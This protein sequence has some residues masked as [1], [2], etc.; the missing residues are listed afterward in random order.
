MNPLSASRTSVFFLAAFLFYF[1]ASLVWGQ[2][3]SSS[4]LLVG[5][6]A[7]L[8]EI[9]VKLTADEELREIWGARKRVEEIL[10]EVSREFEQLIQVRFIWEGWS[11]WDSDDRITRLED[12][13]EQLDLRAEKQGADLLIAVTA[14]QNLELDYTGFSL[15]R[16]G[17]VVV[18][19]TPDRFKLKRLIVHELGHVFGAV[20]VPVANSIM[21]CLGE[22]TRFDPDNL[23]II[24]LGRTRS[25]KPFGFPFPEEV[26]EELEKIYLRIRAKILEQKE[27]QK[28]FKEREAAVTRP[29]DS[30]LKRKAICLSDCFLM[31][32]QLQLEKAE[33]EKAISYSEE[34]LVLNPED[35]EALNL[36]AIALRRSGQVE[37]AAEIYQTIL[38][39][40]PEQPRILFNLGIA[41]GRMNR[42]EEAKRI[43]QRVLELKPDFFEAHNNLGEIFL[44]ENRLDE[45]ERHFFKTIE[46]YEG[47]GLAYSN[48]AEVYSRRNELDKAR[49]YVE[50]ALAIDPGMISALNIKGNLLRREGRL[51]E[52]L[53]QYEKALKR[54]PRYEKALYNMGIISTDL[55]RWPEARAYFLKALEV[56]P[57]FGEAQAGLGLCYLH[58]K[59][60]DEAIYHLNKARELG[61]Q[62]PVI[63]VN[64]SYA[65]LAKGDWSRAE[66]EALKATQEQP[67]LAL[68]YNNLGIALAQQ[69]KMEQARQALNRA[70]ELNPVDRDSVVNLATVEFSLGNDDRA[71]QLFLKAV[72]L[73]PGHPGNGLIYNNLAVIY[74]RKAQYQQSW[75]FCLRALQSGVKV[76]PEFV[77]ELRKKVK[78]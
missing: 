68:A 72:A 11:E 30:L 65:Y 67:N 15:F 64:L 55:G 46:I 33:F 66:T 41:Y 16:A 20:H 17:M 53:V 59:R 42:L 58:E 39:A 5:E 56:D 34:A 44:R 38:L 40:R 70:V 48:L 27:I 9:R 73:Q 57:Y 75:E 76:D 4:Q 1:L 62:N 47:F 61:Y 26:R 51:E 13:A 31:L 45:A 10:T 69:G 32:A 49:E 63:S 14:Q 52:A 23:K 7:G 77:E 50:K 37:K 19:Y 35:H 3:V 28:L 22:G 21:S 24:K 2:P 18:I 54:N 29:F 60:W 36:K 12:F 25:F 71:L 6:P 78:K 74:Y 8:R 43:Y